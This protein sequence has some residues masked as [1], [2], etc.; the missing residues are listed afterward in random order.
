M[1]QMVK[2]LR[3]MFCAPRERNEA[4]M[5]VVVA[6][7]YAANPQDASVS[8]D[9]VID[10]S[11]AKAAVSEYDPVAIQ[12]GRNLAAQ[13]GTEVVGVSV[14]NA[15]IASSMAKKNVLSKGLERAL[16]LADD[17]TEAWNP[18][19]IAA[20]LADLTQRVDDCDILLTGDSSID[21]GARMMPALVAG[22]LGWPCFEEV[23][24]L[25]R[26]DEGWKVTQNVA[27]G[28]RTITVKGSVVAS[29]TS[30]AVEVKV[31]SMKE[32]LAAGKKPAEVLDAGEF[33]AVSP[34]LTVTGRAKPEPKAR[35]GKV[36][37]GDAAAAELVA[38][39]HTDGVI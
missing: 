26:E 6:Y 33:A 22:I 20:A 16:L 25:E 2:T 5:T 24:G 37:T 8:A 31:A 35:L 11:R 36:F 12:V 15:A 29:L 34:A 7:K 27:G 1:Y 14:G 38:A 32:I 28:T 21:E 10:W 4:E 18:T 13:L 30:D 3:R 39:L 23:V 9:G 17:A 19:D